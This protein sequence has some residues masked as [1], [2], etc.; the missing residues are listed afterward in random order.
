[1][2]RICSLLVLAMAAPMPAAAEM[3][4]GPVRVIDGDTFDVGPRR[5]RL[6]GIDAPELGQVCTNPDGA[7]WDCGTW[8]A[9]ALRARIDGRTARCEALDTDRH[10]RTVAR[11]ALGGEDLGRSLVQ[12]GLAF[13]YRR[14]SMDYDLDEKGAAVAGR[15]LH[16]HRF[17]R[18]EDHR[19]SARAERAPNV[20]TAPKGCAI[21]GNIGNGGRRIYHLPGQEDYARTVIRPE[22][23]ERWFCSEAEARAA[24]WRRARR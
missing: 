20:D 10:G 5:V 6:Y 21:K 17:V 23:G 9:E 15:G 1:M 12:E 16:A 19:R 3:F 18:P 4:S 22:R 7:G 8:V 13:A 11:C 24:G 2:L 14:Y